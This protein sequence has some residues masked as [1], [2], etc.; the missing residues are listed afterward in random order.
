MEFQSFYTVLLD[1]LK[2]NF[3]EANNLK[4]FLLG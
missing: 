4:L 1:Y 2:I 3:Y